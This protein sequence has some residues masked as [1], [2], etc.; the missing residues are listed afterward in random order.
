MLFKTSIILR[1]YCSLGETNFFAIKSTI[2]N[3]EDKH[4]IPVLGREQYNALN[5]AYKNATDETLAPGPLKELLE[6]CRKVIAPYVCYYHAPKA[7]AT[8]SDAGFKRSETESSKTAYQYQLANYR[9]ANL[10]EAEAATENLISFLEAEINNYELWANSDAYKTY[11]SLFIRK[12]SEFNDFFPSASPYRNFFA[13]KPKML[14]VEEMGIRNFL[15]DA[16]FADIKTKYNGA[17]ALSEKEQ[18][19]L[20]KLKN[21]IANLTVAAAVPLLNVKI[22]ENGLTLSTAGARSTNDNINSRSAADANAINALIETCKNTGKS[23][24][25]N[26]GKF[27][28][29]NATDFATWPGNVSQTVSIGRNEQNSVFGIF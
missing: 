12:A 27:L 24:I 15:G 28:K 26:A 17:G 8:L 11:K 14:A 10:L 20:F 13:M 23:W 4:I 6:Q 1:Q 18:V 19:L 9:E 2:Q 16:L 21:A 29:E 5:E 22:A 7:D 25:E 3:V